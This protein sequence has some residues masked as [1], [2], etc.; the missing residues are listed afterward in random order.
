MCRLAALFLA[1]LDLVFDSIVA[2][3]PNLGFEIQI[4]EL[5]VYSGQQKVLQRK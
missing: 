1:G 3:L 5:Q 2:S 4:Y